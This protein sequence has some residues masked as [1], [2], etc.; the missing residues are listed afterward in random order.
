MILSTTYLDKADPEKKKAS[1]CDNYNADISDLLKGG[2]MHEED[3]EENH[4]AKRQ[5]YARTIQ[6]PLKHL[7]G[8]GIGMTR[9]PIGQMRC[10]E[11]AVQNYTTTTQR[12]NFILAIYHACS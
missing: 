2:N 5:K 3:L 11:D 7:K 1:V 6:L 12:F 10:R 8:V 9:C 4:A